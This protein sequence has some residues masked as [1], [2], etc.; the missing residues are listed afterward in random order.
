MKVHI[1]N[2]RVTIKNLDNRSNHD[3][4]MGYET[5]IGIIIYWN[6]YQTFFVHRSHHFSFDEYRSRLS[7]EDKHTPGYL[8]LQQYTKII[9]HNSDLLKL[10]PCE[11]DITSTPFIYTTILT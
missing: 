1:N 9:I 11:L 10:I 5:T 3:Y 8:L 2:G 7:L 6:L 4:F